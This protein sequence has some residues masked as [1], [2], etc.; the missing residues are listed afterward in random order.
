MALRSR[1]QMKTCPNNIVQ[2]VK[3]LVLNLHR[4]VLRHS[5]SQLIVRR[6]LFIR[7]VKIHL[8]FY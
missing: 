7:G 6:A 1:K 4:E 5:C 8:M 2:Y 3:T